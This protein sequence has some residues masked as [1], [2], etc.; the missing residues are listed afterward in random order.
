MTPCTKRRLR[1][2]FGEQLALRRDRLA[3]GPLAVLDYIDGHRHAVLALSALE[4]GLETGTSDATVIRAVQSLGFA[5]LR[6]LKQTLEHWLGQTDSPVEKLADT[7][8]ELGARADAAVAYV[9]EAQTAVLAALQSPENRAAIG[10]AVELLGAARGVALFGIGATGFVAEY[11]ARLFTRAG[12]RG[13]ALTATG[14]LLSEQ[15]ITLERSDVL[16]LMAQSRAHR[17]ALVTLAEAERLGLPVV[18]ILGDA[19]SALAER[20]RQLIVLPRARAEGVALHAHSLTAIET[21]HLAYSVAYPERSL[22]TLERLTALRTDI[23][24]NGR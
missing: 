11:G 18:A 8:R 24:A 15:L 12:L 19:K 21:L 16:I 14:G 10:A 6:D 20:A 3:P 22:A 1:D 13:K 4:I 5:G 23:R 7:A 9:V 2:R 17:E